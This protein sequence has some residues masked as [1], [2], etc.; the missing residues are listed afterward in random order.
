MVLAIPAGLYLGHLR[1]FQFFATTVANVGRAVPALG[2][3]AF[4]FAFFG[5]TQT[6]VIIT[7]T[8][9]AVPPL[10]TNTYVGITPG[11]RRHRRRRPRAWASASGTC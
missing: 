2:V 10:F 8:L 5:P 4:L 3:A 11:R 9:L 6:N 7:L 1:R